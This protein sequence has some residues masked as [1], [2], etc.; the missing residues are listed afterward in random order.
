MDGLTFRKELKKYMEDVTTLKQP[1]PP[2][3]RTKKKAQEE[4]LLSV[5]GIMMM[6]KIIK[7]GTKILTDLFNFLSL[8]T[9][10]NRLYLHRRIKNGPV[11]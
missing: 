9:K 1:K 8:Q 3:L 7:W 11:V 6:T 5:S 4:I 2:E 10:K